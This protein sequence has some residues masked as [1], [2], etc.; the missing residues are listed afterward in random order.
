MYFYR[1]F[2]EADENEKTSKVS[3]SGKLYQKFVK[4]T[5]DINPNEFS[6]YLKEFQSLKRKK[7]VEDFQQ[8]VETLGIRIN[9]RFKANSPSAYERFEDL[10]KVVDHLIGSVYESLDESK[11]SNKQLIQKLNEAYKSLEL[12]N[13]LS[14]IEKKKFLLYFRNK[15]EYISYRYFK[16]CPIEVKKLYMS[17]KYLMYPDIFKDVYTIPDLN[18]HRKMIGK[19]ILDEHDVYRPDL[20]YY[21]LEVNLSSYVGSFSGEEWTEVLKHILWGPI[22]FYRN[23]TWGKTLDSFY[24]NV[25]E[26]YIKKHVLQYVKYVSKPEEILSDSELHIEGF[27]WKRN[28][29][30]LQHMSY[31]Q[32]VR[33]SEKT[34]SIQNKIL[35]LIFDKADEDPEYSNKLD[36]NLLDKLVRKFFM[37]NSENI[38]F[39]DIGYLFKFFKASE[40]HK[41]IFEID[42][43][44]VT[45]KIFD[46]MI[47]RHLENDKQK[48][49][50][51][52]L[53]CDSYFYLQKKKLFE[54]IIRMI[55]IGLGE[56]I[57]NRDELNYLKNNTKSDEIRELVKRK[58]KFG[59][60][61]EKLSD[62]GRLFSR[63]RREIDLESYMRRPRERYFD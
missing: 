42:F 11:P 15:T 6:D 8:A 7:S 43:D 21:I 34:D 39:S 4:L 49:L 29:A 47:A 5:K 56:N 19:K 41:L 1:V 2:T 14:S 55:E 51:I 13:K 22:K 12:F 23:Y 9:P 58:L 52:R 50:A 17:L 36:K 20:A 35:P 63:S 24:N 48:K 54:K 25:C 31:E 32:L 40:I 60:L 61:K 59:S 16:I 10:K 26:E 46:Y 28:Y 30:I 27:F 44:N 62:V 38:Y 37:Y 53:A 45:S 3:S 18:A 57:F 33:V